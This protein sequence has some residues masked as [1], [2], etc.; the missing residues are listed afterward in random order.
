MQAGKVTPE[1][2]TSSA[3]T[4]RGSAP[5]ERES[6]PTE[7]ESAHT[8]HPHEFPC[9]ASCWTSRDGLSTAAHPAQQTSQPAGNPHIAPLNKQPP[10]FCVS[11]EPLPSFW[12]LTPPQEAAPPSQP[13]LPQ[14]RQPPAPA[15]YSHGRRDA[16]QSCRRGEIMAISILLTPVT[17]W[18][19]T[20]NIKLLQSYSIFTP[21]RAPT[22]LDWVLNKPSAAESQENSPE[23]HN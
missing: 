1:V 20:L 6:A 7:R 11:Q 17:F 10:P 21:Q 14:G 3:P 5:T 19:Q 22:A 8:L 9:A 13:P 2:V 16:R 12:C 23:R 18:V 4:E 15:G